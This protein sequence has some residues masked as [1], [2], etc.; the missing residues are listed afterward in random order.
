VFNQQDRREASPVGIVN[1]VFA[2]REWTGENPIGKRVRYGNTLAREFTVIGVVQNMLGQNEDDHIVR[3][4]Y[5]PY[6]QLPARSMSFLVRGDTAVAGPAI[7]QA[8]RAMDP[9]QAVARLQTIRQIITAQRSQYVIT[10][11]VTACFGALALFLA[12]LGIYGVMA[13]SVVARSREFGIRMALGARAGDVVS[14]VVRQGFKLALAGLVIGLIAAFGI[15]RLMAFMLYHVSPTDF[16]TFALTSS[17]LAIT[18]VFACYIPARR[19]SQT[20][21]VR[22]LRHE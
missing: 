21:P 8:V 19:A 7:R 20:D 22:A 6:T 4:V 16:P 2:E 15:T 13:Y 3:E 17:L 18:A 9:D 10:G 12:A 1:Q 11:Q 5:L 14:M